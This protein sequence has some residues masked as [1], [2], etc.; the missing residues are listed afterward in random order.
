LRF[1]AKHKQGKAFPFASVLSAI[2]L[3]LSSCA[4]SGGADGAADLPAAETRAPAAP[5][6]AE[7]PVSLRILCAG[8]VM[9]HAPQLTAQRDEASGDYDFDNNFAYVKPY[10]SEADLALCNL[11]TTLGGAPYTGY[12]TFSSPDS[13]A[14]AIADAGFD[15]IFTSNNH[16]L[17]RGTAGLRRTLEVARAAGLVTAGSRLSADEAASPIVRGAGIGV[18]LV[19]FTYES[20]RAGASRTLNGIRIDEESRP[21]INSFGYEDLDGDLA[22][23][24]EE[25][26]RVRAAGAEIVVCYFHW[27]NE[28]ALSQNAYQEYIASRAAISGADIIFASHPHVPQGMEYLS[29]A[30]GRSVPVFYSLGNFISNQRTETTGSRYTEQGLMAMADVRFMRSSG[31]IVR[32]EAKVLPTWTDK[33]RSG[34]KDVYTIVPLTDDFVSNAALSASGNVDRARRALEYCK[35]LFGEAALYRG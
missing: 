8:D 17:D 18:G 21:L 9:V 34:G 5:E 14:D 32:I 29:P 35:E 24:D 16:M 23:V 15:A 4:G 31:E 27:G 30:P 22:R 19:S 11:E 20:P 33:Y 13:L 12:P 26:R 3:L 6:V 25:I 2:I 28:Y 7:E 10:V 1:V